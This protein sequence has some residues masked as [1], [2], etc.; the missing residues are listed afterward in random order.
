MLGHSNHTSRTTR[1]LACLAVLTLTLNACGG[2]DDDAQVPPTTSESVDPG[3]EETD[4]GVAPSSSPTSESSL[5]ESSAEP[6]PQSGGSAT[7]LF[8]S[9]LGGTFDPVKLIVN[10]AVIADGTAGS[11]VYGALVATNPDTREVEPVLAESLTSD[12][13]TVWTLV[14]KEGLTFTDGTPFDAAAVKFNW[15]RHAD[16]ANGSSARGVIASMSSIE[17]LDPVTLQ[18]TLSEPNLQFPRTVGQYAITFIASPAAIQAGTVGEQ[19]VG[20]GPFVLK[21]WVRDDH[22]T[23][24]RNDTYWDAPRPYLDE[25]IVR[26]ILDPTQR[27]NAMTTGQGDATF[28]LTPADAARMEDE[29]LVDHEI[30]LNGGQSLLFNFATPLGGDERFRR[31]LRLAIDNEQISEV[32]HQGLVTDHARTF[33]TDASPFFD[34]SLTFAEPD[35]TEAQALVDELAAENGGEL[36]FTIVVGQ[37]TQAYGEA[38]QAQLSAIDKL[39]AEVEVIATGAHVQKVNI[40]RD[41]VVTLGNSF[42][43]DPEPRTHDFFK[44]GSPR[45]YTN[46]TDPA[47]DAALEAG[48]TASTPEDRSAAYQ[49]VQELIVEQNALIVLSRADHHVLVNPD[50]LHDVSFMEDGVIRWDRVWIDS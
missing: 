26:P 46:Y 42:N 18:I 31:A 49:T 35:L 9:E 1:V 25:V 45:N 28:S 5:A 29:G 37:P 12:D 17:V 27:I 50:R 23:F 14:L 39:N 6:E 7:Y 19:P 8:I 3:G 2:D 33:F 30:K 40:Q 13:G 11:L 38:L 21:E 43:L 20:A 32:V 48:R 47:M 16:E 34:E 41:Y 10:T 15:E 24:V 44:T 22:M 4:S 36:T